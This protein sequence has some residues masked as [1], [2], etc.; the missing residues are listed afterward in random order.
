PKRQRR[1]RTVLS[2]CP[3][4]TAVDCPGVAQTPHRDI[5]PL[6]RDMRPP[7]AC[8]QHETRSV[9]GQGSRNQAGLPAYSRADQGQ[10][11]K[12]LALVNNQGATGVLATVAC[13]LKIRQCNLKQRS[14]SL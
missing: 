5:R 1:L 11:L 8:R 14:P 10:T 12:A 9:S 3:Q 6:M 13:H 4:R 2:A 7:A